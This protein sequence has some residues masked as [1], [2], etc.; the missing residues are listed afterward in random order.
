L[1]QRSPRIPSRRNC[2]WFGQYAQDGVIGKKVASVYQYCFSFCVFTTSS[3]CSLTYEF[4]ALAYFATKSALSL[5]YCKHVPEP[6][7]LSAAS[8]DTT[9]TKRSPYALICRYTL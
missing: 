8:S 2:F 1:L 6:S 7:C 5:V 3:R 4:A 9:D